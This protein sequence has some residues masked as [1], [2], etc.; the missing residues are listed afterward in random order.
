ME[1][2]RDESLPNRPVVRVVIKTLG[3]PSLVQDADLAPLR[4]FTSLRELELDHCNVTGAGFAHLAGLKELR[5]IRTHLCPINDAGLKALPDLPA[6]ETLEFDGWEKVSNEGFAEVK[7]FPKLRWLRLPDGITDEGLIHLDDLPEL[8]ELWAHNSSITDDGCGHLARLDKLEKLSLYSPN[9]TDRGIGELADLP[10]LKTLFLEVDRLTPAGV[11]ALG[12]APELSVLSIRGPCVTDPLAAKAA[13]IGRLTSL[14]L[15]NAPHLTDE[16][17][18]PIGAMSKLESLSLMGTRVSDAGM[19]P[20]AKLTNLREL[21]LLS[22]RVGEQ[23]VAQLK[24]LTKLRRLNLDVARGS[25]VGDDGLRHLAGKTDL[26][27]L[28]LFGCPVTDASIPTLSVF[29]KL[30]K[31]DIRDT[32]IT[33]EGAARLR[34]S[35]PAAT[36]QH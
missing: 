8:R 6:L 4:E 31:L 24:G 7:R 15:M 5:S 32:R 30:K 9:V 21:D 14:S 18:R 35:L 19:A 3:S 36:I 23:G 10:R 27:D 26:E 22:T 1:S 17:L 16:G 25:K 13:N 12:E 34:K 33:K 28:A 2:T 20:V 11:A 29:A